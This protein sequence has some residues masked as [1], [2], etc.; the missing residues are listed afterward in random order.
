MDELLC[1]DQQR[2]WHFYLNSFGEKNR[3]KRNKWLPLLNLECN[4]M[5]KE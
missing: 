4:N 5:F 2:G 3:K 1:V